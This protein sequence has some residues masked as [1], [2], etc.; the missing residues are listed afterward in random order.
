[1]AGAYEIV[2]EVWE[3]AQTKAASYTKLAT[4]ATSAA[5]AAGGAIAPSVTAAAFSY[6]PTVIEPLVNIPTDAQAAGFAQFREIWT[7][8]IADLTQRFTDFIVTYFP[9]ETT[10][11]ND[12]QVWMANAIEN[13]GTGIKPEIE[14]QIWQRDR[15]RIL[16]EAD[17]AE[18]EVVGNWANKGFPLPTGAAL[19]AIRR[20]QQDAR[21]KIAE[22]SSKAAVVKAEMEQ[23]NIQF[24]VEH[25]VKLWT[26]AMSAAGDYIKAIATGPNVAGQ[27]LPSVTDSQ[28]KLISAASEY[29]KAR[30]AMQ[31]LNIKSLQIPAQFNQ[32]A[33]IKNGELKLGWLDEQVKAAA[34]AAR[35]LGTLA[36]AALNSLHAT[37]QV[38]AQSSNSVD[39]RYANDTEFAAPT[40]TMVG[41]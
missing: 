28:S 29:Y 7:E 33:N 21:D 17:R 34:E 36:S 25:A 30:I 26:G 15:E 5:A 32:E 35:V 3:N 8:T 10:Y 11:I 4:D 37:A 19:Y 38:S 22:A 27:V 14:D 24:A 2:T 9:D 40:V 18:N 13:G 31:E 1:M 20:A 6:T 41:G 39:Y 23:K 16:R 12:A